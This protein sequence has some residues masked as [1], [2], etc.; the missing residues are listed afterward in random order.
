MTQS[1]SPAPTPQI[2][3]RIARIIWA[4]LVIGCI[5]IAVTLFSQPRNNHTPPDA[6]HAFL[7]VGAVITFVAVP[8]AFIMRGQIFKRGWVGD[9]VT[10]KAFATGT[11]VSC[12]LCE[13]ACA[14]GLILAFINQFPPL[15]CIAPAISFIALLLLWPNGRAMFPTPSNPDDNPYHFK[16]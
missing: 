9:V 14:V 16:Q 11:I 2:T 12:A 8:L 4:S 6:A 10:P 1:N 13:G 3:L 15:F 5:V 7:L